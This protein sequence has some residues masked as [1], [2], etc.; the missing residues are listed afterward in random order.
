MYHQTSKV[1]R[2]EG[3][4]PLYLQ[5]YRE[6]IHAQSLLPKG[7]IPRQ[8]RFVS[9]PEYKVRLAA[10][11]PSLINFPPSFPFLHILLPPFTTLYPLFSSPSPP[12][13]VIPHPHYLHL[14]PYPS[15]SN[16]QQARKFSKK[17]LPEKKTK[18][19][20]Y[21]CGKT[22]EIRE[23]AYSTER[24]GELSCSLDLLFIRTLLY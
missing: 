7:S 12:G 24:R 18:R 6:M 11:L 2:R 15:I 1:E 14:H 16:R 5:E 8:E 17:S 3:C 21:G 9:V 22:H 23:T 20:G 10:G 19:L 4:D 13:G